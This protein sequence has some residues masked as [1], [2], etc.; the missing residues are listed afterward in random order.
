MI[1]VTSFP[2]VGWFDGALKVTLAMSFGNEFWLELSFDSA[3][4]GAQ[5]GP[6]LYAHSRSVA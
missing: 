5:R 2:A 4:C 1:K 3:F 6:P